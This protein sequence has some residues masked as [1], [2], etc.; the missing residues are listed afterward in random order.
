[1]GTGRRAWR[2]A[3]T[4]AVRLLALKADLRQTLARK[5]IS[6][7]YTLT[8]VSLYIDSSRSE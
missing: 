2:A 5:G 6:L 1:M 3:S 8:C 4:A 7:S